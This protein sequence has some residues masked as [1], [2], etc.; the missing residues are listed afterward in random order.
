MGHFASYTLPRPQQ[1]GGSFSA[2]FVYDGDG[3]RV[4]S[5]ING[6][7]T[8]FVRAHYEVTGSTITK[9]YYAGSQ[10]I[11]MRT[12][13]ALHYLLGDHLD[14]TSLTVNAS[15]QV[16]S[17]LRYKA[18]GEIRY[19]SGT[20]PTDY[21]YTGQY[22][23]VEDFGLHFYNARWY[24]SSLGR[25]AQ[26]DTI[27]PGGV[28]GLDRYA[29]VQN[30]PLLYIDPSGHCGIEKD[31]NGN[32]TVGKLDCTAKDI[33]GWSMAYRLRW[34]KL[35][36]V[37]AGA[38]EWFHNIEGIL[39][40]FDEHNLGETASGGAND[41]VSWTDAG[42][43]ESIQNGYMGLTEGA[44][45][46]WNTFFRAVE[47]KKDDAILKQLW[48]QAESAGTQYGSDLAESMG[49]SAPDWSSDSRGK[50][51]LEIG[52]GYRYITGLPYG[53]EIVGAGSVG[54]LGGYAGLRVCGA[55]CA[56]GGILLG[57]VGGGYTGGWATNPGSDIGGH[58]IVYYVADA[59]LGR[60]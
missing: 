25:F 18:W 13:G 26:A 21:T 45:G 58:H 8:Y 47:A 50:L 36:T 44:A 46:K 3:K 49:Y 60:K 51:F 43:L 16:V 9:Y 1:Q 34:F 31:E 6:V 39:E 29:Y 59:I 54:L 20:T 4:K 22:S 38:S 28:Q 57:G 15:G 2:T 12:N 24:D 32:E 27:V 35:F 10:R 19:S 30:N 52:D 33:A 42:L 11:V 14:S 7:T 37:A 41:W 17:E 40:V 48:G 23:Y 56:V 55:W 53:G 5:T